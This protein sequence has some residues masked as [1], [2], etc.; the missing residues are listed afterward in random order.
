MN[1]C[2]KKEKY[3]KSGSSCLGNWELLP[4]S[5]R[6]S[7]I[8]LWC[9]HVKHSCVCVWQSKFLSPSNI[10]TQ[11]NIIK[12][13]GNFSFLR[14]S[15]SRTFIRRWWSDEIKIQLA[16]HQ[17]GSEEAGGRRQGVW[18]KEAWRNGRDGE[19]ANMYMRL[20]Q[21]EQASTCS[22]KTR[23]KSCMRKHL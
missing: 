18:R 21:M 2:E 5:F 17:T 8:S 11:L 16:C 12:I 10:Y 19:N 14:S 9:S 22:G 1:V 3:V 6:H 23:R 13:L 15:H 20:I 7:I 4:L